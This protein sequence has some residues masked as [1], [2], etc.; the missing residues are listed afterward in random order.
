[1]ACL[2]KD[3][4]LSNLR[5]EDVYPENFFF[6]LGACPLPLEIRR[7]VHRAFRFNLFALNTLEA[8]RIFAAI[9]GA[10]RPYNPIR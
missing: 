8:K 4:E 7:K 6:Y 2:T 5:E 9:P 3:S 1:L 10:G